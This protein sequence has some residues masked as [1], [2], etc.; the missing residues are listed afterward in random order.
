[1]TSSSRLWLPISAAAFVAAIAVPLSITADAQS[2]YIDPNIRLCPYGEQPQQV[3]TNSYPPTCRQTC[4]THPALNPINYPAYPQYPTRNPAYPQY[5]TQYPVNQPTYPLSTGIGSGE[6]ACGSGYVP[7]QRCYN[8]GCYYECVSNRTYSQPQSPIHNNYPS[9]PYYTY[10]FQQNTV[11]A[12]SYNAN[13]YDGNQIECGLNYVPVQK[14][15]NWGCYQDCV[16]T[17]AQG[18]QQYPARTVSNITYL[19]PQG[20][21]VTPSNTIGCGTRFRP[22]QKC[23]NWGCFQACE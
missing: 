3:C 5:P 12:Y 10:G 7:V 16:R 6:V 14:C 1:M 23:Y 8:W 11:P 20:Y 19:Q 13:R 18:Y 2:S 22:V 9:L 21:S 4:Y 15:F 17:G